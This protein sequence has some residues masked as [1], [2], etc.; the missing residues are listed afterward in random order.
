METQ[1]NN[2]P[3]L[4]ETMAVKREA[5]IT[6]SFVAGIALIILTIFWF[7]RWDGAR[8]VAVSPTPEQGQA[9][10]EPKKS[11]SGMI[12][13]GDYLPATIWSFLLAVVALAGG[14]TLATRVPAPGQAVH[15][16]RVWIV[17]MGAGAGLLTALLGFVLGWRWQENLVQWI[18][19]GKTQEARWVLAA[20]AIFIGGLALMF[21]S[22]QPARA[23]ERDSS[24]LRRLLYGTNAVLTGLL[25]V[26]VLAA[27]NVFVFL[28]LPDTFITTAAAFKGLGTPAKEF[29]RTVDEDVHIYLIMPETLQV[30]SYTGLYGDCRGLLNACVDANPHIK[31]TVL[32]PL[33]DDERIREIMRRLKVPEKQR[34]EYGVLVACGP[35]EERSAFIPL[36]ELLE[37]DKT[38]MPLFQGEN[39]V[40]TEI[41][42]LTGGAQRPVVYF[43]QSNLEPSIEEGGEAKL[44]TANRVVQ[45]LK[46]RRY[47][48]KPLRFEEGKK[49]DLSD[50]TMVVVGAPRL[51][52]SSEQVE[53]LRNYLKPK[54]NDIPGGKLV[55]VLPAFMGEKG[56][57]S[58]TGLEGLCRD[59]GIFVQEKRMFAVS[60]IR[61]FPEG[62]VPG[63]LSPECL[64]RRNNPLSRMFPPDTVLTCANVRPVSAAARP[65]PQGTSFNVFSSIVSTYRDDMYDS[66]LA[67]IIKQIRKEAED[68]VD[69]TAKEKEFSNQPVA[70]AAFA[71]A[72]E[73]ERPQML[74]IGTDSFLSDDALQQTRQPDDYAAIMAMMLDVVREK[75]NTL[76]IEPR[77]L[78]TYSLSKQADAGSLLYLPIGLIILGIP[79]LGIGVW[80]SRRQ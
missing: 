8:E 2:P 28:K 30:R 59:Y 56:R 41:G 50:A 38:G 58:L 26:L 12:D 64:R 61:G 14:I 10:E 76:G 20:L 48:V 57:V 6:A 63:G 5:L 43:T 68:R 73:S 72:P 79:A 25:V 17:A 31:L 75:T 9:P 71:A 18:N 39:R 24:L 60:P 80:F 51:P 27:V 34:E 33:T 47:E 44:R 45:Q 1:S 55:A 11:T 21:F 42:F 19:D 78:G 23:E 52:F 74:V 37:S 70:F 15:E 77:A 22:M 66:N 32:F 29:L 54:G 69:A 46:D 4:L 65:G 3:S 40:L 7:M 36:S 16:L 62:T 53:V 13:R 49:P 35:D 67:A